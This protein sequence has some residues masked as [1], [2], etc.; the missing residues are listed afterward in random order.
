LKGSCFGLN[1][2]AWQEALTI[3]KKYFDGKFVVGTGPVLE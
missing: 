1:A 2:L 3:R